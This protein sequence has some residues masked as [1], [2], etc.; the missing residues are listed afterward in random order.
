MI[1]Q[2][3]EGQKLKD[4]DYFEGGTE[5]QYKEILNLDHSFS[6]GYDWS[7]EIQLK[8]PIYFFKS[9]LVFDI[10]GCIDSSDKKY[11]FEAYKQL[12]I[13]TFGTD[14]DN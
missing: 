7:E 8:K 14:A 6:S 4:W 3:E 13:N 2:I 10:V 5:E 11:S 12:C 1:T 9:E